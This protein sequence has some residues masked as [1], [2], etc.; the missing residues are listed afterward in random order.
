MENRNTLLAVVLMLAVWIG[1]T[2]LYPPVS[3]QQT[4]D[5]REAPPQERVIDTP[6]PLSP[7]QPREVE[8]LAPA[9]DL[10]EEAEVLVENDLYQMRLT[11]RGARIVSLL[12]KDYR[13]TP[14]ADSP[15]VAM[16]QADLSR[17]A[18][19]RTTGSDDFSF[20]AELNYSVSERKVL[21]TGGERREIVFSA[22]TANGLL[23]E[24][25]YVFDGDNYHFNL[26]QRVTNSAGGS[27]RG[28]VT[29]SL[30]EPVR[31]I[32]GT[33]ESY[34]G[35]I[36][37]EGEKRQEDA[38]DDL[39]KGSRTYGPQ[40]IW[41]GY[42]TKYFLSAIMPAPSSAE[43]VRIERLDQTVE[44]SFDT[45]HF[46]LAPG[47]SQS[48]QYLV[49]FGPRE[50]SA[51]EK[52]DAELT[53]AMDFGFFSPIARPLL[54]T[55]NFFYSYVGNYGLAI[56]LVTVIIKILFW[57][58]TH[59]SYA[60]M[61]AMQK[62]QPEMQKIREKFKN[63]K[64]KLNRE[65]MELYKN[66]R[67]NP[68]GGCL[69]MLVQIPVFFALYKV[70]MESIEMRHA[71]FIWWIT[72]LSAKDP[73]YVTPLIM[74]ATMFI[75]QKLTPTTMDPVQA[76]VFMFMPIVFTFLFLNFPSGLVLYWLVNNLLTIVQ[77]V[78]IHR[79]A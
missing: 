66:R 32:E 50:T 52:A 27:Q 18:S 37:L 56:I 64:E 3:P 23:F 25:I 65:L 6:T 43:R 62:L 19:L 10:V 78:Y 29:L 72:D 8:R 74:G 16:V 21:L 33:W 47:A 7:A 2:V 31:E 67:V 68:L 20:P 24:K 71:E 39:R 38:A 36:T 5:V 75:Q 12:L 4:N 76:K 1:F 14:A 54:A 22:R 44:I 60:S 9:Q 15:A 45:P 61:K 26:E 17:M 70:L 41:S 79:K 28:N 48:F 69:P 40:V 55:L 77:Q 53:K 35:P 73:Y 30:V 57:P 34:I 58:L 11:S 63:D 46:S 59:K 49:Y 42:Q 13:E 51:L